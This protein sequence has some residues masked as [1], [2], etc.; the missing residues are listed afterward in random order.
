MCRLLQG[1][2]VAHEVTA[3]ELMTRAS[4]KRLA[5]TREQLVF[6]VKSTFFAILGSN[7]KSMQPSM[8]A[9]C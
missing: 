6:N 2:R 3:S 1:G 7:G 9:R 5:R 4:S 8:Q